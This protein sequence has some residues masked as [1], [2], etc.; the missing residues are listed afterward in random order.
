MEKG[1]WGRVFLGRSIYCRISR[2]IGGGGV[3][4]VGCWGAWCL[5][6]KGEIDAGE[7]EG[8]GEGA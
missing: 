3:G 2:R 1:R 5:G 4:F 8:E 6:L 7:G